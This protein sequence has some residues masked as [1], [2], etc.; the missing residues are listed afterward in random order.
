MVEELR[1]YV[2]GKPLRWEVRRE[3]IE[4]MAIP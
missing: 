3:Q 4:H 2:R 1:R